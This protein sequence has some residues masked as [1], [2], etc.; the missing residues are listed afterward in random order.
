MRKFDSSC[1]RTS[2]ISEQVFAHLF[3]ILPVLDATM[4]IVTPPCG[5][6]TR[7][8]DVIPTFDIILRN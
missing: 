1:I 8:Y 3:Y 2:E 7:K 5:L 6:L 4:R